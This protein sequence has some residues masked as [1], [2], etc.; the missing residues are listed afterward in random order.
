MERHQVDLVDIR[1]S[2]VTIE[3][4]KYLYVVSVLDVLVAFFGLEQFQIKHQNLSSHYV[5]FGPPKYIQCD[6]GGEFKG[7]FK[8]FC[9]ALGIKLI[10]SSSSLPQSQGKI[11]RS[12]QKW[13]DEIRNKIVST[14]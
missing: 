10:F 8:E 5:E 13:K 6:Q 11:E 4:I 7:V 2:A 14:L 1:S 9:E 3:N 12:H